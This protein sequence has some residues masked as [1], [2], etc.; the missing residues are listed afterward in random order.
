M[1]VKPGIG[2][3]Q[4]EPRKSESMTSLNHSIQDLDPTR[5]WLELGDT[6]LTLCHNI[7]EH[8]WVTSLCPLL[9]WHPWEVWDPWQGYQII[10]EEIPLACYQRV[11]WLQVDSTTAMELAPTLWEVYM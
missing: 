6:C 8:R 5:E 1:G 11:L 10:A 7:T 4:P 9:P 2:S 3:C